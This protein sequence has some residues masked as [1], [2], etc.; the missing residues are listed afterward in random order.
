MFLVLLSELYFEVE[1]Y[2]FNLIEINAQIFLLMNRKGISFC[3]NCYE[4]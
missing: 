4:S 1:N 3:C 2:I